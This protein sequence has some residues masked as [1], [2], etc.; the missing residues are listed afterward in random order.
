MPDL[1]GNNEAPPLTGADFMTAWSTRQARELLEF[2]QGRDAARRPTPASGPVIL[3]SPRSILRA[4]GGRAGAQ[5]LAATAATPIGVI[6]T[7][8]GQNAPLAAAAPAQQ[9]SL[10]H[11]LKAVHNGQLPA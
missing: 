6:A 3:R 1:R 2:I 4:N 10:P 5:P 9:P 11:K 8:Q 7:G